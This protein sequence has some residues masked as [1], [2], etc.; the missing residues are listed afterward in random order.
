MITIAQRVI[1]LARARALEDSLKAEHA[2]V[3]ALVRNATSVANR[4]EEELREAARLEFEASGNTTLHEAVTIRN[5]SRTI[6]P[7]HDNR[8]LAEKHAPQ[9]ILLDYKTLKQ[10][11]KDGQA[12]W[13]VTEVRDY[14]TPFIQSKLGE[15]LIALEAE[16]IPL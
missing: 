15:Y 12:E 6:Y 16:G 9:L 1:E 14:P 7:Y 13:A 2:E 10:M 8:A 5:V 11:H 3:L 4:I